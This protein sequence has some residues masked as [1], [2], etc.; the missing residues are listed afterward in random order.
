MKRFAC[1]LLML[2]VPAMAQTAELPPV[3]WIVQ[4]YF[5]G[6]E[7]T[8]VD[9]DTTLKARAAM[10]AGCK[11]I[12]ERHGLPEPVISTSLRTLGSEHDATYFPC[13]IVLDP[14]WTGRRSYVRVIAYREQN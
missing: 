4:T 14:T 7:E 1:L 5:E 8:R 11:L 9:T 3:K 13:D 10:I 2:A 12:A 6:G